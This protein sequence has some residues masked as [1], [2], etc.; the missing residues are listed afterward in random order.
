MKSFSVHSGYSLVTAILPR[1][2]VGVVTREILSSG[3]AHAM[4]MN[5]RGTLMQQHW[6]QSLLPAISPEQEVMHFIVPGQEADRLM[7][8]IVL[9]GKLQLYGAGAIFSTPC[10]ELVCADDYPLWTPGKYRFESESFD[11][12]F[13]RDLMALIHTTDRGTAEPI[14]RAAIKAGAQ[15]ATITYVRGYGLR[16]R[17]GLLRITK[18]HEK[19]LITVVVDEFDLDAVFQAMAQAGRVEQPGRGFIYHLPVSKGLTNLASVF[20]A[21][22]HSVSIQQMVRAIDSLHGGTQWRANQLLIHDP[23]SRELMA[24]CRGISRDLKVVNVVSQRK[25][26]ETLLKRF[27]EQGVSGASVSNWRFVDANASQTQGG[28]RINREFGCITLVSSPSKVTDLI[29]V[30]RDAVASA[31][32][33][34]TCCFTHCVPIVKTFAPID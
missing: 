9:V 15:G 34:S 5:A 7:E 20:Q 6:Y 24:T 4:T 21:K 27:L 14:A 33:K 12:K 16:D 19:E 28:L 31:D 30:F 8:Q 2:S 32:M 29:N 10:D 22:K 17:L 11:I 26:S 1:Q 13:K 25:D 3:A 23:G 18:K